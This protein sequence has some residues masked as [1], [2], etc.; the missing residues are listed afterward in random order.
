MTPLVA[1][2]LDG[3]LAD[4]REATLEALGEVLGEVTGVCPERS[5]LDPWFG[6]PGDETLRFFGCGDIPGTLGL[7]NR[8]IDGNSRGIGLFPGVA[9]LLG[10]LKSEHFPLALVTSR[11]RTDTEPFLSSSGLAGFF[12]V[13]IAREDTEL[14]KPAADPLL[15]ALR[16]AGRDARYCLYVG[17]TD[18][19]R[20]CARAAQVRFGYAG[21]NP[22]LQLPEGVVTVVGVQSRVEVFHSPM[23]LYYT[24][25]EWLRELQ[26]TGAGGQ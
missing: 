10:L 26:R 13:V 7:W 3:T 21:W 17:D 1:F 15:A 19:D 5:V 18:S 12:D 6:R 11:R 4:S 24:V 2:D 22:G 23:S 9:A 25:R 16:A 8:K 20:L 14:P